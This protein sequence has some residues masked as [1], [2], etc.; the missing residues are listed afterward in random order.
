MKKITIILLICF[1]P[2]I[3]NFYL[4]GAKGQFFKIIFQPTTLFAQ[5]YTDNNFKKI[6]NGTSANEVIELIGY[7]LYTQVIKFGE[8]N[9]NIKWFWTKS[10]NDSHYSIRAIIFDAKSNVINKIAYYYID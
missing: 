9:G 3:N 1:I 2:I 5:K 8:Y 6:K 10:S 7:P 4:D